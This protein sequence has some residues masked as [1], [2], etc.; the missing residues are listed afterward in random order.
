MNGPWF[1]TQKVE[2]HDI[3]LG[4]PVAHHMTCQ[5]H[6]LLSV[7]GWAGLVSLHPAAFTLLQG[8]CVLS[9]QQKALLLLLPALQ[10]LRGQYL[11]HGWSL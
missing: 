6:P 5:F 1:L 9:Q 10:G 4:S 7:Q 11:G 3:I 8:P 2:K